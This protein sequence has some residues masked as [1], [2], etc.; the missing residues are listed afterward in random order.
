[1]EKSAWVK[2]THNSRIPS[3]YYSNRL[4]DSQ[5]KPISINETHIK[6][7]IDFQPIKVQGLALQSSSYDEGGSIAQ[8]GAESLQL[9]MNLEPISS[10]SQFD[11]VVAEA[12][13]LEESVVLLWMASW[14][15]KCIYL[16]PKLEKLAAEYYPSIRFYA[17]DVNNV[18]HKLVVRAGVTELFL[19]TYDFL[20]IYAYANFLEF[21]GK[22]FLSFHVSAPFDYKNLNRECPQSSFGGM[23]RNSRR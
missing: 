10:E 11:R 8:P 6:F 13:Q 2:T 21:D 19:P 9:S 1:M 20:C 4:I 17:I 22:L 18:P 16:K 23:G 3:P 14:C 15:R 5:R 12:Q 7:G